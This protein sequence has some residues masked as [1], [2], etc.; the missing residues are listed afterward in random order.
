MR[1]FRSCVLP[2]WGGEERTCLPQIGEGYLVDRCGWLGIALDVVLREHNHF[3]FRAAGLVVWQCVWSAGSFSIYATLVWE[4]PW[5]AAQLRRWPNFA[6]I[7]KKWWM[8][9]FLVPNGCSLRSPSYLGGHAGIGWRCW[10]RLQKAIKKNLGRKISSFSTCLNSCCK[11][12]Y[13]EKYVRSI[14]AMW[15]F[16]PMLVTTVMMNTG[17]AAWAESFVTKDPYNS[18]H[19]LLTN[20]GATLPREQETTNSIWNR[21]SCGS[22]SLHAV[23]RM[24]WEP[25]V[26]GLRWQWRDHFFFSKVHLRIA[27]LICLLDTLRNVRHAS[28]HSPG[29]QRSL[30]KTI[31]QIL[32]RGTAPVLLS[33]KMLQ[34][35]LQRPKFFCTACSQG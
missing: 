31:L 4:W 27:Q 13:P 32:H 14:E 22:V 19:C 25:E 11:T 2:F 16:S 5:C 10:A 35:C 30:R 17:L 8:L 6:A 23:E 26:L 29:L 7:Y 12:T 24:L 1:Y 9:G 3:S 28:T 21:D 18:F 20:M 15:L 34:M 33:L